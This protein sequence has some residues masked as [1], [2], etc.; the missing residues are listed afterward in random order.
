[1]NLIEKLDS[2]NSIQQ[3][4]ETQCESGECAIC[5]SATES[6]IAAWETYSEKYVIDIFR[7]CDKCRADLSVEELGAALEQRPDKAFGFEV[8]RTSPLEP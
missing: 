4:R 2:E 3:F 1:M 7:L 5:G 6:V 8:D